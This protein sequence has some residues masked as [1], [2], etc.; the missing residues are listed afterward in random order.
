M[1][2]VK[3][4]RVVAQ[5]CV[6]GAGPSQLDEADARYMRNSPLP[7]GGPDGDYAGVSR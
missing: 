3:R 7:L 1:R 2:K 4:V 6:C 5:A